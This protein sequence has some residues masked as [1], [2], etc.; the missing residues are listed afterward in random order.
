MQRRKAAAS[1]PAT[2][3]AQ[4]RRGAFTPSPGDPRARGTL[5]TL[6]RAR[7]AGSAATCSGSSDGAVTVR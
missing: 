5:A 3:E 6:P 4:A 1:G 2:R 7:R